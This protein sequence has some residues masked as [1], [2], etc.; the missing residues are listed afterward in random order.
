MDWPHRDPFDR[1]IAATATELACAVVSRDTAFD[2]L[3]GRFGWRGRIWDSVA[4]GSAGPM[5]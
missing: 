2:T 3:E 1:V 4:E 5:A